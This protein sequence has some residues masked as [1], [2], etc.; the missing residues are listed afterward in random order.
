[1]ADLNQEALNQI[2]ATLRAY[3]KFG[4]STPLDADGI[5]PAELFVVLME[6]L[7]VQSPDQLPKPIL[8]VLRKHDIDL[9]KVEANL[10]DDER[11]Q[12][13]DF[14]NSLKMA[15]NQKQLEAAEKSKEN[16]D[17]NVQ[18]AIDK[19]RR[20]RQSIATMLL[21]A[22]KKA[23]DESEPDE[24][25]QDGE[26]SDDHSDS[27]D[28]DEPSEEDAEDSQSGEGEDGDDESDGDDG[29]GGGEDDGESDGS[30]GG[31]DGEPGEGEGEGQP[32]EGNGEP[33]EGKGKPGEGKG[34]PGE[35]QGEGSQG[36]NQGE[37]GE[38]QSNGEGKP[39]SY[40]DQNSAEDA[41]PGHDEWMDQLEKEIEE[42]DQ[43]EA[44]A[45]A[46]GDGEYVVEHLV[47][48]G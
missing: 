24:Q 26:G 40:E 15:K 12:L 6:V 46:E 5:V 18:K 20:L 4:S 34:E 37:P 17:D 32:G 21:D 38:G 1:M 45:E 36:E 28:M 2:R 27:Q 42:Q 19:Q 31:G 25:D 39:D 9:K 3:V 43:A 14:W 7:G 22:W 11:R 10:T 35:G 33:G 29:N 13:N 16:L 44:E 41:K 30:D 47:G 23:N 8:D 48:H